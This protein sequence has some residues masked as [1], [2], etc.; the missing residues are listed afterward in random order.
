M[1]LKVKQKINTLFTH[2]YVCNTYI[3]IF[4]VISF[5]IQS[6]KYKSALRNCISNFKDNS[7]WMR[8]NEMLMSRE[9]TVLWNTSSHVVLTF[10][11]PVLVYKKILK[12]LLVTTECSWMLC[13]SSQCYGLPL[14]HKKTYSPLLNSF[15]SFILNYNFD[16]SCMDSSVS[17]TAFLDRSHKQ[18]CIEQI[19]HTSLSGFG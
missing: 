11:W 7:L 15:Y 13:E 12:A 18:S 1:W 10:I 2:I 19:F 16:T 14:Y 6:S 9:L 4:T 5:C 17:G 3:H 8:A